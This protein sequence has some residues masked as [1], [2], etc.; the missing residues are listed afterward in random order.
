MRAR[1]AR[2]GSLC[3]TYHRLNAWRWSRPRNFA[4]Y[5]IGTLL[6][7]FALGYGAFLLGVS[8]TWIVIGAVALLGIGILSGVTRT[9]H[10]DPADAP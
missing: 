2:S 8:T 3:V 6:V 9:R 5:L 10:R 1:P 4:I 7:I